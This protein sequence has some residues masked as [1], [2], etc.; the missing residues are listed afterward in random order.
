MFA[1]HKGDFDHSS[2]HAWLMTSDRRQR[3]GQGLRGA[4]RHAT[5][6]RYTGDAECG[7]RPAWKETRK[8]FDAAWLGDRAD[9]D[10]ARL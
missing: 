5:E 2:G 7:Y 6:P 4:G 1:T 9:I 8:R 3:G 10:L